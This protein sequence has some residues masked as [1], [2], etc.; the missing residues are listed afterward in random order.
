M[1]KWLPLVAVCLGSFM[2]LIDVTIVNVALPSMAQ[3]L[4]TSFTSLQ[5][6]VDSYA[7][8]LAALLLGVGSV[9]DLIGHRLAYIGG[10][11]LFAVASLVCGLAPDPGLLI[12]AR[13]IQG[14]GAAAMFAT[15][16]ALLNSSYQGRDRGT[17]YGLWGAVVGASAAIGPI[18][19]GLLTQGLSWRWI[20]FVNLPFSVLAIVLSLRVFDGGIPKHGLRVDLPG[21]AVFTA[22]AGVLT[23][24]M[25]RAN[26]DGWATASTFGLLAISVVAFVL[27]FVIEARSRSA[28]LDLGLLRNKAF[29]GILIASLLVNFAAFSSFTYTSIWL[30]S[31]LGL[32]PIESGMTGL[33]LSVAAF[34]VSAGIGRFLHHRAPGPIIGAGM[35]LIGLGALANAVLI[36]HGSSWPALVLGFTITGVGVGLAT[37]TLNSSAM[38][39]VPVHRGGMAAGAVTTVRQLGFAIGIALLGTLFATRASSTVSQA[40]VPHAAGVAHNLAG[41][42]VRQVL[43]QAGGNRAALD[44][45]LHAAAADGLDLIFLVSGIAG[46][47]GGLLVLILV[48]PAAASTAAPEVAAATA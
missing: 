17:A 41:G 48:R 8:T 20:F 34:A 12:I 31:L 46:I 42:Q 4:H 18:V 25:I 37:P 23:Y 40:G 33:P 29:V 35:I 21:T 6:V 47:V 14:V 28:M 27:F 38:S 19:G 32:S 9:A 26:D 11:A 43:A 36:R 5:W 13:V 3:N 15:T 22:A 7:V 24:A 45:T 10:L 44:S 1:R 39:A 16:F 2:L 30:Q